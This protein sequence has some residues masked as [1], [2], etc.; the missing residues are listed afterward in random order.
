[1]DT[2]SVTPLS[3]IGPSGA[4][5]VRV[6]GSKSITNRALLLAALADGASRLRGALVSDDSMHFLDC[7]EVLGFD[8]SRNETVTELGVH[9][10]D[11]TVTGLGGRIP[12]NAHA[13]EEP[14]RLNVG[15]A[16]TCARFVTAMLAF[17]G[18]TYILDSSEQMRRR[19]MASLLDSLISLG[20]RISYLGE[21]GH[22]PFILE[23]SGPARTSVTVNIDTSSQY[24]SALL[25]A[26][27]VCGR[28]F[29]ITVTGTHGFSYV[30]MTSKLM[31]SFG[32][33]VVD[34]SSKSSEVSACVESSSPSISDSCAPDAAE[35]S[36][37]T[38]TFFIPGG[39]SY[40]P[41]DYDIEPDISAACYFYAAAA[42]AGSTVTVPGVLP[43]SIQGDI[44]FLDVLKEMG[45]E[46]ECPD[47]SNGLSGIR[48]TGPA[49]RKLKGITAD[50]HA[51]SDQALTLAAVAPFADSPVR[52]ENVGHIRF[53]ESDR[54][55]SIMENL[56]RMGISAEESGGCITIY[57]DTPQP[58]SIA[59]YEDHRVAM[60]FAVTG[61][62]TPGITIEDPGCCRKTFP[63]F[64]TV[65][66]GLKRI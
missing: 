53:Q 13:S 10:E 61:L 29:E 56:R 9:L 20:A 23:S 19:P 54:I 17:A 46:L 30:E 43:G 32:V 27:P 50:M 2:Y 28:D 60:A 51:F 33:E 58:A 37:V 39:Q 24:L 15:S 5:T 49:G 21:P 64:F 57:P 47:S 3:K 40:R 4:F 45:A 18:G 12:A 55:D 36:S 11:I 62:C 65:L 63:E 66:E 14:V 26:A 38:R 16:G 42:A 52:I 48:L 35:S 1:M 25:M 34:K 59:T 6:P 44:A 7:L 31:K 8:I 22:F 41:L